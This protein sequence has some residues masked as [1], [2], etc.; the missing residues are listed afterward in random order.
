MINEMKMVN[1]IWK[2][3]D[4]AHFPH[5]LCLSN[6]EN[7][8]VI[9]LMQYYILEN[10]WN[11]DTFDGKGNTVLHL[12]CQ[13]DN[14][15]LVSYLID[16]AQCNPNIK[17]CE[18]SLP[19]GMTTNLE[20]INYLCQHDQVLVSSKAIIEWLNNPL[21]IDDKTMLFILRSLVDNHKMVT[22]TDDGSTL[23]HVVCT[24]SR[25]RDTKSLVD[26]LL[27]ECQYDPNCLDSKGQMP[28]QLTSDLRVMKI[29]VEHGAIMTANVI[30]KIIK[31][32]LPQSK[33]V[34]LF[35]LSSRKGTI[36][37][38]PTDL[39]R[40]GK[41]ALDLAYTHNKPA[42]VNY[43]LTKAKCDPSANNVLKSLLELTTNLN[44]AKLLIKHGARVTPELVLRFEAMEASPNKHSLIKLMLTTWN[45][46]DRGSDGYTALHLA[47]IAGNPTLV[48]LLIS[49][50]H[51]DPNVKSNN[52]DSEVPI[53]LT[54]DLRIMKI[55]V[56]HGAQ[57]TTDVVFSLIS[58]H[59][60]DSRVSDLFK[61][62]TGK[63]TVVMY[64][65]DLNNINDGYNALHLACKADSFTIVKFLLSVAHCDPNI[66]SKNEEA[67][68]QLTSD[69]CIMKKL[70]EHGAHLTTDVVFKLISM[71]SRDFRVPDHELFK[72]LSTKGTM[73]WN[74]NYMNSD[75]YTALHL[76]CKINNFIIVNFLLSVAN[77]DPNINSK[78]EEVPIQ[79]TSDLWI[80]KKLVEH[81]AHLTTDVVF[82]LISMHSRDFRVPDHELFKILSTKGT[83]IWNPN[84]MNSDGYTALHL[85]CKIN[86]FIIVNFLLSVAN[87][88]PNINSKNG[89]VPIQLTSDLC[90][91]KKL[92]E[93]G[94]RVTTEVVFKLISMH[95]SD[96]RVPDHELFK[97][98]TTNI[99]GTMLWNPKD[100]NSDGYT[101]LHLACEAD[102]FTIVKFL[103]SVAH[104]DP[105][106][107]SKYEE[108]PI[109]LTSNLMIMKTLVEHGAQM[110]TDIVFKL[111]SMQTYYRSGFRV[112][113]LFELSKM[114][115]TMLWNPKDLNSDGFTALH[116][117]CQANSITMVN[118]LLSL[119]HCDPNIKSKNEV[120]PI[121]LTDDLGIIKK[122]VEHGAQMTADVVFKLIS[123][124]SRDL[125]VSQLFKLSTTKGTL[126]NPND[127][128]SDGYTALHL[129]CQANNFIIVNYLLSVAQCDPNIKSESE[130]ICL[131]LQ[132]TTNTD[133][134]KALIRHGAKT[135]IMYESHQNPL[136]TNKPLQPPVKVFVVGNPS[137]G[138][139]TLTAALKTEKIGI[140]ARLLSSG[141]VS[142][143]DKNT[144][145]IVPHD[146]ES[147]TLG[148]V[149]L[150]DFA[151][152]REFYSGHA[153]LL[154]TA[155]QSTPPIFIVVINL[156]EDKDDI[157]KQILYWVSF[158]ENQCAS[159]SCKPHIIFVGSHADALMG[160]N[161]KGK[162]NM[163][164]DSLDTNYF[165]NM[166]Y[167]GFVAM[168]CQYHKSSGMND[169]RQLLIKSCEQLRIQELITFN[170]HCFLV[171][172]ID[173]FIDLP[174][175]TIKI[176][177]EKIENQQTE[178]GILEFLPKGIEALYKICLE[179]NDRGHILLLKD[180]I[181]TENSYVVIDKTFLLSEISGTVFAPEGFSQYTRLSTNSGV[182]PRSK[183]ADSFPGKDL[184]IVIG[185]LNH[186]EF[187]HEIVDQALGQLISKEYS[188]I[189]D[190]KERYYLFPGLVSVNAKDSVWKTESH[191]EHNF[192]WIL[193]CINDEQFFS[194]R[195]LQVLLL[196]LAFS[197]ALKVSGSDH[198]FGIH[199]KCSIWKNGIFWGRNFD[200]CVLVEMTDNKLVT[201]M[202]RFGTSNLLKC[203]NQRSE[204]ILTILESAKQFCPRV[205][206]VESFIDSSSAL[207][208]PLEFNSD[209]T[210]C[211][212]RDLSEAL[213]SSCECPS[214]VLS[215]SGKSIPAE[216]LLSFEPYSEMEPQLL[217]ELWD[218][219]NES[220]K[221]FSDTFLSRFVK[222]SS[223]KPNW[224]VK[225]FIESAS[226]PSNKEDLS[227][228]LIKWR[229]NKKT[230][231]EFRHKLD[232][233]SVFAER[234]VLVS[235]NIIMN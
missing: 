111:I 168:D 60:T 23:L 61:L 129:A 146:V 95:S 18:G 189:Y 116:L 16:Q 81:G 21:L 107:K 70:V 215:D 75:G 117:A 89:E 33:A 166:K 178:R 63:G 182:V 157:V 48:E 193:K 39:N 55:L 148:R 197:F 138:K 187:C 186:L 184:N 167:V 9:E 194:S 98:L 220:K 119:A 49:V 79:L 147:D 211:S 88:D 80:M 91:M 26:Y 45:P 17:N 223:S 65:N 222:K 82:K 169:L 19:V 137:V 130:E 219:D 201:L 105:N 34:E 208:Y 173:T 127:L 35:A 125:R 68:I 136:G 158:L 58:M 31:I 181:A 52:E 171:Y 172:L 25:S 71:H 29:L 202:A 112:P 235:R 83:M 142:G 132:L 209:R 46:D 140:F 131:P 27:T 2:T 230:Y 74:P 104:C 53:Q 8:K 199:R 153:A 224:F 122:L 120:V 206:T 156:C 86:N 151:G 93:H 106:A 14:L 231:K 135:S 11:P 180:R 134:I 7:D 5:V 15:A 114:K 150:Y 50:A 191:F 12:A 145:G 226:V 233:Y 225:I 64:P 155:I 160:A 121:Q 103:L 115:G 143:V 175:V 69:L 4:E 1:P 51:C 113:E 183:L 200:M 234:N 198:T 108:V 141:R 128:N 154:Q 133:I 163:I 62:L 152:H 216:S 164:T 20:V 97:L 24:C 36:L 37:W 3:V 185:F 162:I 94:A 139:S 204:V 210:L 10:G 42:I 228:E 149:T 90:I 123:M 28:L 77:C 92:V 84:Y 221:I 207:Q 188:Q 229:D 196:R 159:V 126:R 54:S 232:E 174:A 73:I 44:V 99:K 87:C 217:Q 57:M 203:I 179:L 101:A 38:H 47:C 30:F 176:I 161:P 72:I 96:L 124:H 41:T 144:V 177:S 67:P 214:V 102:S 195:F 56:E 109:Q 218:K 66:K 170:A 78:N 165:T 85:A 32:R 76:A 212:V 213:V 40:N 118:F 22:I 13:T 190:G 59:N 43:L 192:G 110:T 100:M 227:R 205:E 6:V